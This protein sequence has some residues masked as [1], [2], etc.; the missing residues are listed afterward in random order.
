MATGE[1][2]VVDKAPVA[3]ILAINDV[4]NELWAACAEEIKRR[5]GPSMPKGL[6][7]RQEVFAFVL[8]DALGRPLLPHDAAR[9]VGQAGDNAVAGAIRTK[10]PE[11]KGK[12]LKAQEAA[13]E[14]VR[15][16]QR[17]ATKDS[18]LLERVTAAVK[19][20]KEAVAAMLAAPVDLKLPNAT[21]GAKRKRCASEAAP[22]AE[23]APTPESRLAKLR[24]AVHV[25]DCALQT[26]QQVA[27]TDRHREERAGQRFDALNDPNGEPPVRSWMV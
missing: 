24:Q 23:A 16:A 21:V 11:R 8:N 13:R 4:V 14:A 2:Q 17:A 20:G 22:T 3:F 1:D 9:G 18:A 10:P 7:D 12:L 27:S 15:S 5:C 25:A 26:A 19:A 6:I